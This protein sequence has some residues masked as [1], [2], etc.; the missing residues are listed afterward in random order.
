MLSGGLDSSAIAAAAVELG[1]KRFHSFSVA[2]S[3]GG[4]YSEL[5]YARQVAK[6]LGARNHEV[7]IDRADFIE[8]LPQ[9]IQAA[10]EPLADKQIVPFLALCRLARQHVKVALS[11]EGADETLAGYNFETTLRKIQAIRF[12]QKLPPQLVMPLARALRAV[13]PEYGDR[14]ARMGSIPLHD[15]NIANKNHMTWYWSEAEKAALWP[16]FKGGRDSE[17]ILREM[18]DAAR[19]KNPLDQILSVFQKS[20]LIDDLLMKADKMSMAASLEVRV[21]FLDYRLVEWAN[22]Q[23]MGVRIGSMQGRNVTKRVLRRFAR[24]RLPK[25]IIDRPKKGFPVPVLEW[26][27]DESFSRWAVQHLVGKQAKLKSLFE[28]KKMEE[29]LRQAA[30]GNVE[31]ANKSWLLIVLETWLREFDVDVTTDQLSL[32][33]RSVRLSLQ[34]VLGLSPA[35]SF[36]IAAL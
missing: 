22:R 12:V 17:A 19:S 35:L 20:W 7:V 28:P 25:A 5:T 21:P 8:L 3:D 9:A 16:K 27:A 31:A 11:G 30:A 32:A 15:W 34:T 18:Y 29:Q 24:S 13:S 2:F 1:H 10:D 14:L 4:E 6:H 36:G 33:G 23:P 26:L